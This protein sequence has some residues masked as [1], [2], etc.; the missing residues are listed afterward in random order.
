MIKCFR[1]YRTILSIW[2]VCSVTALF[3]G[4]DTEPD[5][6]TVVQHKSEPKSHQVFTERAQPK[7]ERELHRVFMEPKSKVHDGDSIKRAK[8]VLFESKTAEP[9]RKLFHNIEMINNQIILTA[10]LRLYGI[11]TPEVGGKSL[12]KACKDHERN[13]GYQARDRVKE[14]IGTEF[15]IKIVGDSKYGDELVEVY[16]VINNELVNLNQLLIDERLAVPYDGGTK[17]YD[18]CA[19]QM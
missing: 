7:T 11:D 19:H 15:F 16:V 2:I 3:F 8:V 9:D 17:S 10:N 5:H 6:S 14:L 4:C 1:N 13:M 12:S 18:W